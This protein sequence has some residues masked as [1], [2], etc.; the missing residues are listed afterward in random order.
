LDWLDKVRKDIDIA[1]I[2]EGRVPRFT[3]FYI[4]EEDDKIVGMIAV[5]LAL[6]EFLRNEGGHIGY[7]VRPGERQK[8]YAT[9]MLKGALQFIRAIGLSDAI[10]SC[11][12]ENEASAKV[13]KNCGGRLDA[14]FYSDTIHEV[15]QRYH[16]KQT[17]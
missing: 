9:L 8:G 6:N 3:Y 12:K 13:I 1:N 2:A 14:E 15:K 5:R 7:C 4:R 10:L 16:I 11:D 17:V